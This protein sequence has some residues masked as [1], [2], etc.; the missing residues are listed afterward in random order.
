[1]Q[2]LALVVV[3]LSLPI[4]AI[5]QYRPDYEWRTLDANYDRAWALGFT[6]GYG[7]PRVNRQHPAGVWVVPKGVRWP[8]K[9]LHYCEVFHPL[10][11]G[12]LHGTFVLGGLTFSDEI[13]VALCYF[14]E[15]E[16]ASSP[17]YWPP[18]NY[19]EWLCLGL[20]PQ[21][22]VRFALMEKQVVELATG[23]IMNSSLG[24]DL[25]LWQDPFANWKLNQYWKFDRAGWPSLNRGM[26]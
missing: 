8:S 26:R 3:A 10:R 5:A 21:N 24:K 4:C 23:K 16:L 7:P 25:V 12:S 15:L 6:Y 9:R 1:M 14:G 20:L 13:E 19:A 18:Q 22:S 2:N 11:D 17:G